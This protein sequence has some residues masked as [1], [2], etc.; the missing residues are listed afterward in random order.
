MRESGSVP[1]R[2]LKDASEDRRDGDR[3]WQRDKDE[4]PRLQRALHACRTEAAKAEHARLAISDGALPRAVA[5]LRNNRGI[6]TDHWTPLELK[7]LL[8]EAIANLAFIETD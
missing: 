5:S 1:S 2:R 8:D 3:I 7:A 6:G 4:L